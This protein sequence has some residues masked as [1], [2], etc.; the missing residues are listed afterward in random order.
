MAGYSATPLVRK[1]GI[2][3]DDLV[4]V[5][6]QPRDLDV[7]GLLG[8]LP[9]NTRLTRRAT[10]S[11][12]DLVIG[13]AETS[14]QLDQ[15]VT[16]A[17]RAIATDGVIWVWWPK[18]SSARFKAGSHEVTED[19]VRGLALDLGLVDVKVC[20]VDETWSGLKLVYR[21]ANR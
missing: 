1:L 19:S 8:A 18:K 2:K 21:L 4:R 20:A 12:P 11:R 10:K 3:P 9:S 13:V 17:M 14:A 5:L 6:G 16:T 15:V 7:A